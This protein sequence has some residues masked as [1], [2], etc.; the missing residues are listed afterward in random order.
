[1]SIGRR[2]KVAAA[3]AVFAAFAALGGQAQAAGGTGGTGFDSQ[4]GKVTVASGNISLERLAHE[5]GE[6]PSQV[7]QVTHACHFG[8][9]PPYLV[10]Y[11]D[12]GNLFRKM[13][14]GTRVIL[15]AGNG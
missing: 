6:F 13:R 8:T 1:M 12:R 2:A 9:F 14:K 4:C 15:G 5:H 10:S 7:L 3:A 11:I